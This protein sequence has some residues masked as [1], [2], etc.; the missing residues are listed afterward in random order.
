MWR[1]IYHMRVGTPLNQ[2]NNF[3]LEFN[4]NHLMDDYRVTHIVLIKSFELD[5]KLEIFASFIIG[6]MPDQGMVL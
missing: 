5:S 1:E 2:A 3:N 6:F 4:T